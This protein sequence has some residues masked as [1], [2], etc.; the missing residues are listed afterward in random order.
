MLPQLRNF[1]AE[2][3]FGPG[4]HFVIRDC[5]DT[6]RCILGIDF[7]FDSN[8]MR[9]VL[10]NLNVIAFFD[11]VLDPRSAGFVGNGN[12]NRPPEQFL[13]IKTIVNLFI[14]E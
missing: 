5:G 10:G 9:V 12:T 6:V 3:L 1:V 8:D 2:D 13:G 4:D 11:P 14:F 7:F